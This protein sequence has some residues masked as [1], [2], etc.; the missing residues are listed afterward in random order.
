MTKDELLKIQASGTLSN[1][2]RRQIDFMMRRLSTGDDKTSMLNRDLN[3]GSS[4]D[5]ELTLAE[6]WLQQ[7]QSFRQQ[8]QADDKRLSGSLSDDETVERDLTDFGTK[9]QNWIPIGP[10]GYERGQSS[11]MSGKTDGIT[12]DM[13]GR[14]KGISVVSGGHRVY[15]ATANGGVWFSDNAGRQWVSLMDGLDYSSDRTRAKFQSDSLACGAIAVVSGGSKNEDKIYLGTGEGGFNLDA[16]MG[17]GA[18]VSNNGGI[19]WVPE[20][21]KPSLIG[22]GF[23]N[24]VVD[25]IDPEK[26]V[27]ATNNGI[28]VR[29]R[30]GSAYEWL[31]KE[32]ID[33]KNDRIVYC[34][35]GGLDAENQTRFYA[36]V[37]D[38]IFK[39][40]DEKGNKKDYDTTRIYTSLDATTWTLLNDGL[41]TS[42]GGRTS[43][44]IHPSNAHIVYAMVST[45]EPAPK[46]ATSLNPQG[47]HLEGIYR[48]D[49]AGDKK[50]YKIQGKTPND[51]NLLGH[52]FGTD[53]ITEYGQGWYDNCLAVAPDNPNRLYLGGSIK[54]KG[55][56]PGGIYRCDLTIRKIGSSTHVEA[57]VDYIGDA[58]HG[59]IQCITF[60][61]NEPSKLWLGCDGG[62]FYTNKAKANGTIFEPRNAGLQTIL[63]NYMAFSVKEEDY[64]FVCGQDCG[65]MRY[66]GEDVWLHSFSGDGGY[67]VIN[68]ARENEVIV[69]YTYGSGEKSKIG[70]NRPINGNGYLTT[71]WKIPHP[72]R[73]QVLFYAPL[74]GVPYPNELLVEETDKTKADKLFATQAYKADILAFG[75]QRP[76]I[77]TDFGNSWK[78]IPSLNPNLSGYT[79]DMADLE[80]ENRTQKENKNEEKIM[81]MTFATSKILLVGTTEGKI[82]CFI[83]ESADNKWANKNKISHF[84]LDNHGE[85]SHIAGHTI[86]DFAVLSE[87]PLRFYITLGGRNLE[88]IDTDRVWLC[89]A[90]DIGNPIWLP[91]SGRIGA[92]KTR[93][94][95]DFQYNSI[96]INPKS[97][98]E[99]FVGSDVGVWKTDNGGGGWETFSFGLP[100]TPVIDLKIFS[101]NRHT[102]PGAPLLLRA[103]TH[104]RGVYECV[105]SEDTTPAVKLYFRANELDRGR[106]K[107]N[108]NKTD[109]RDPSV[110]F[111]KINTLDIKLD[112][113]NSATGFY[114]FSEKEQLSA[115]QFRLHLTDE[116]ENVPIPLTGDATT[117]IFVQ[118]NSRG[119]VSAN[120]V[121]VLLLMKKMSG[122]VLPNLP[123]GYEED[124]KGS[125]LI[126]RDGWQTVGFVRAHGVKAGVA[127]VVSFNLSSKQFSNRGTIKE[128]D[129]FVLVALLH[130]S[131]DEFSS[132]LVNIDPSVKINNLILSDERKAMFKVFSVVKPEKA[133]PSIA[134]PLHLPLSGFVTIPDSAT[135]PEAPIDAFLGMAYRLNDDVLQNALLSRL[136][137]PFSNRG[138]DMPTSGSLDAGNLYLATKIDLDKEIEVRGGTPLIWYAREKIKIS[139]R[140]IAKGK[141]SLD[142]EGDFGGSGGGGNKFDGLDCLMPQSKS[143][144]IVDGGGVNLNG[145]DAKPH[146]SSRALL[147]LP[148]CKGGSKGGNDISLI[149]KLV[150]KETKEVNAELGGLG[151][152]VVVL[153]APT[154]EF[155]GEGSIDVSGA[156]GRVNAGG[157][158]GGIII[159]IASEII[160]YTTEKI[161][162]EG[163]KG[164]GSGGS[165][166]KGFLLMKRFVSKDA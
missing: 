10:A 48:L 125:R 73:E 46:Q 30:V 21:A 83:D 150:G 56:Y 152:G 85:G 35:A 38:G 108:L 44:A 144:K 25:P 47:G 59:D 110:K 50:W 151:G 154:I 107:I 166:G 137:Q 31:Q 52:V 153:C 93:A 165:G 82:H 42:R 14:V 163:G 157:G 49:Y 117:R 23:F 140:I 43:L 74:I 1:P 120:N 89:D 109:P 63:H 98:N 61:P 164:A 159:L 130:H 32:L 141:G 97:T 20:T 58:V 142:G 79:D 75:T 124:L 155:V 88:T 103:A 91:K 87:A 122:D 115:G 116:S 24:L 84:R 80:I 99:I 160:G 65:T 76:W 17:I 9:K 135:K 136:A 128:K 145:I 34:I 72:P 55:G 39:G 102:S 95:T 127:Q 2:Q 16:Y 57:S 105:L 5:P 26:V 70:G 15:I 77:S 29:E 68:W 53:P 139:K 4:I 69:T 37:Q 86:T 6:Q 3:D 33:K 54:D 92:G 12:A 96:V 129:K 138:I 119:I 134:L 13:S 71:N 123:K 36:S 41:P 51:M 100:E 8:Q 62:V 148:F 40:V 28:Y 146:W 81:S 158:G 90:S 60:V 112:V 66:F 133:P 149:D 67:C 118:I 22:K 156:N 111:D 161:N 45:T 121:H 7:L 19:D 27:A 126:D 64:G 113:P 162:I 131:Q 78:P 104:G 18:M 132:T 114:K 94:L 106:Y 11:T 147:M 101:P 143:I